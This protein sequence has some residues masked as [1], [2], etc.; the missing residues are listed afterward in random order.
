[1]EWK[2]HE[3]DPQEERVPA[4][5]GMRIDWAL[6]SGCIIDIRIIW[7]EYM[8]HEFQN[9]SRSDVL[10]IP[11]ESASE[12]L[13]YRTLLLQSEHDCSHQT[14]V[15]LNIRVIEIWLYSLCSCKG[16]CITNQTLK[17][18]GKFY[19]TVHFQKDTLCPA[20]CSLSVWLISDQAVRSD[21]RWTL[22]SLVPQGS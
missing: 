3:E 19:S 10:F 1:M 17:Y 12:C 16:F 15:K 2:V 8:Q 13:L 9:D 5:G 14:W 11:C 7:L 4:V 20:V 21:G 18:Q 22:N 6:V